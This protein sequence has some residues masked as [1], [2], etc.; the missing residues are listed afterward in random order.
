MSDVDDEFAKLIKEEFGETVGPSY[1]EPDQWFSMSEAIKNTEPDELGDE[2]WDPEPEP[3]S[4]SKRAGFAIGLFISSAV[5]IVLLWARVLNPGFWLIAV[6]TFGAAIAVSL[7]LIPNDND[8]RG[9]GG[10]V[11]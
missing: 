7:T 1:S 3:I 5:L 8:P 10:L 9:D 2:R 6:I 11:L 4:F